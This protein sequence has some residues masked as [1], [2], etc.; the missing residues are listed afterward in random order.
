MLD[1]LKKELIAGKFALSLPRCELRQCSIDAVRVYSGAGFVSQESDG[2][3]VLRMFANEEL[4]ERERLRR[5][6]PE[7]LTPGVLVPDTSYY[8]LE[9]VD[10]QGV[11]WRAKRQSIREKFGLGNEVHVQLRRLEKVEAAGKPGNT[12]GAGWFIPG[13]VELPWHVTTES[14]RGWAVDRFE[15]EDDAFV[16]KAHKTE[17]GLEAHLTVK[18]APLEPH[19]THFLRALGMLVGRA[20]EPRISYAVGDGELITRIHPSNRAVRSILTGPMPLRLHEQQDAHRFVGCCMHNA[21]PEHPVSKDLLRVLYQFWHRILRAHQEDIE[22]SSLVLS[23]AIEGTLKELF[24][25]E[26]DADPVFAELVCQSRPTV[27]GLDVDVRV[28]SSMLKSLDNSAIAKPKDSLERLKEQGVITQTHIKA[29]NKMRNT[30]VH[31][32]LLDDDSGKFQAHLNRYF[33]CLDLF[34]RLVLL[35]VGYRGKHTDFSTPGWPP[36]A[37]PP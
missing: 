20:M 11:T 8:D 24:H 3:L 26:H 6:F 12:R 23:V 4:E 13:E 32:T 19:A 34:Y 28:R 31:G 14:E 15:F 1:T 9:A 36:R 25:S 37:F 33:C 2:N 18:D 22:N 17:G 30:G 27:E 29:W 16:W 5:L 7:S 35:A 10:Q 21:R